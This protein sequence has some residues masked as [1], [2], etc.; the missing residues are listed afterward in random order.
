MSGSTPPNSGIRN[1][2]GK[3]LPWDVARRLD[4]MWTDI[5][6]IQGNLGS[7]SGS[8]LSKSQAQ[9]LYGLQAIKTELQNPV[10]G[11]SLNN[12]PGLTL[13]GQK[14][15]VPRVASIPAINSAFAQ[16][17][18][19]V[20]VGNFNG[21]GLLYRFDGG[22]RQWLPQEAIGAA[23][24][25]TH[26]NRLANYPPANYV[27]GTFFFETDTST[28]LIDAIVNG[29]AMWIEI[30]ASVK[31][32]IHSNRQGL[33]TV[34]TTGSSPVV[35][36]LTGDPFD[37]SWAGDTI[38]IDFGAFV[39]SS[40][41]DASHLTLTTTPAGFV[42]VLYWHSKYPSWHFAD[43]TE[44]IETDRD[45]IYYVA[46]L[47]FP[48]DTA[49]SSA[50]L[51]TSTGSSVSFNPYWAQGAF[52]TILG[53]SYPVTQVN[54]SSSITVSGTIGSNTGVTATISGGHWVYATGIYS[55]VTAN[56]PT[57]LNQYDDLGYMWHNNT[58]TVTYKGISQIVGSGP[59][60]QLYLAYWDG[61][62]S[63]AIANIPGALTADDVGYK[64]EA[65]DYRH[66]YRWDGGGWHFALGDNG[67]GYVVWTGGG[68]PTGGLWALCQGQTVNVALDNG[69]VGSLAT[70][71]FTG[72]GLG[73][74]TPYLASASTA[75]APAAAIAPDLT[76]TAGPGTGAPV[77]L[78]LGITPVY[79]NN[80]GLPPT[81]IGVPYM[82][83]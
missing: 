76:T 66:N 3:G 14:T 24:I 63:D 82:R 37:P 41:T 7:V 39:I 55:D 35:T 77:S 36:R 62:Y 27:P 10:T 5:L 57:N 61:I 8:Y 52:I 23:L 17:G 31:T 1:F 4:Q 38:Y 15:F 67:A 21:E 43:A 50:T 47:S 53:V 44:Y 12:L 45:V 75:S 71:N 56:A 34:T 81:V 25:D 22:T 20:S 19:L 70:P 33:G 6:E 68:S 32:D 80:N 9:S 59:F 65:T 78:T 28:E 46:D 64:F 72:F 73:L 60:H 2:Q 54:N 29:T 48:V 69:S 79:A 18:A 42:S 11:L 26:A 40:V 49:G 74:G 30:A 13:Q 16:D 51:N 58:Q 83:C